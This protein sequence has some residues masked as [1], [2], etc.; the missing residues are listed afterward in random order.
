[1]LLSISL[2]AHGYTVSGIICDSKT[3]EKLPGVG[4]FGG[5]SGV[6]S[7]SYG[8]YTATIKERKATLNYSCV[9][10]E[11][12]VIDVDLHADTVINIM[13]SP[14]NISLKELIVNGDMNK[15]YM[16]QMV[17]EVNSTEV[18]PDEI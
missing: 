13:L 11:K 14:L 3:G 16:M 18:R 1:M 4:V 10:F 6:V 8:F 15:N 7:N 5:S 12:K 9:G 2:S 17:R